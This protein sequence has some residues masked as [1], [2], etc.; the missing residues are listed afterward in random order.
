MRIGAHSASGGKS[1]QDKEENINSYILLFPH[2]LLHRG[3]LSY[4]RKDIAKLKGNQKKVI[5]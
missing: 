3:L 4:L 2:E 1:K 5:V